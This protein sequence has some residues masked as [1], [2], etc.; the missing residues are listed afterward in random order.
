MQKYDIDIDRRAIQQL[1]G[2]DEIAA[3]FAR[4]GYSTDAR[5]EQSADNLGITAEGV[6]RPI[7]HIW[8]IADEEVL[9]QVY[10][11]ELKSVTMTNIRELLSRFYNKKRTWH[12]F[13][14]CFLTETWFSSKTT[15]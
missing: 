13:S 1:S 11:F 14:Y 6:K 5:I 2:T 7:K 12:S 15:S 3:F 4:L 9:L 10:L 8:L